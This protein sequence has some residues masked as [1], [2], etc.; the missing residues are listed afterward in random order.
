MLVLPCLLVAT[1]GLAYFNGAPLFVAGALS[2][3]AAGL[4]MLLP[5]V[6]AW[7]DFAGTG[8]TDSGR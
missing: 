6:W 2:I 8:G 4:L 5:L 1:M 7:R 3:A